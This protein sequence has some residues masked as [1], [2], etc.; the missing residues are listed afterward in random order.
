[1]Y[2]AT[3]TKRPNTYNSIL[4]SNRS[5]LGEEKKERIMFDMQRYS[6]SKFYNN[7]RLEEIKNDP[8]STPRFK[9]L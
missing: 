8:S 4:S 5:Y 7:N 6:S 2:I 9:K 1:M 3:P